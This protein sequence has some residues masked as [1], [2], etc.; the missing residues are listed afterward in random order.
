MKCAS[1][2]P[3]WLI[4]SEVEIV[5]KTKVK[6]AE[7]PQINSSLEA[8][9]VLLQA[10]EKGK[11]DLVEQFNILLLCRANKVL[12]IHR[13]SSGGITATIADPRLIFTAALKARAV[14]IV[15][16]HNH[17]SGSLGP[18]RADQELTQKLKEGGK[19][20]DI[21]VM[22]HLIITSDNYYSFADEGIL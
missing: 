9:K 18:S 19:L 3:A 10:W 5:Y 12:G 15:L 13:V 8:Y 4:A 14:S 20:L 21:K 2:T 11:I 7:R 6:A 22:D 1:N 17:P 16:S